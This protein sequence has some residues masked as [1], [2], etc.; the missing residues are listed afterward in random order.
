MESNKLDIG[1]TTS[2]FTPLLQENDFAP[3]W[4][5]DAADTTG[6]FQNGSSAVADPV[7]LPYMPLQVAP[8]P[9]KDMHGAFQ[10]NTHYISES[11]G[12]AMVDLNQL[13]NF[14]KPIIDPNSFNVGNT[15]PCLYGQDLQY[16]ER[17]VKGT[18]RIRD[19][20]NDS[21]DF[22]SFRD[23][24][25]NKRIPLIRSTIG[26][27]YEPP[28]GESGVRN[29]SGPQIHNFIG[30]GGSSTYQTPNSD[31]PQIKNFLVSG[32]SKTNNTQNSGVASI[33]KN[34]ELCAA[35]FGFPNI[36]DGSFLSLGIGSNSD[37]KSKSDHSNREITGGG[38]YGAVNP[39]LNT[40]CAQ[41]EPGRSFNP[42]YNF[43]GGR[44]SFQNNVGG[45]SSLGNH[46]GGWTSSYNNFGVRGGINT[47]PNSSQLAQFHNVQKPEA[48]T[49]HGFPASSTKDLGMDRNARYPNLDAY[50]GFIGPRRSGSTQLL[51]SGQ[52]AASG[53]EPGSVKLCWTARPT[54]DRLQKHLAETV[55]K[56]SP[57]SSMVSSFIGFKGSSTRQEHSGQLYTAS[58]HNAAQSVDGNAQPPRRKHVQLAGE[59]NPLIPELAYKTLMELATGTLAS[60][61]MQNAKGEFANTS[62][63]EGTLVQSLTYNKGQQFSINDIAA[64]SGAV[65]GMF[66]KRLGVQVSKDSAPQAAGSDLFPQRLGVHFNEYRAAPAAGDGLFH[67]STGIKG[68]SR[69][70]LQ[71]HLRKDLI[72]PPF[73]AGQAFSTANGSGLSQA[74]NV[75]GV[76]L[77]SLKRRAMQPPPAAPRV[78][79][80]KITL[81]PPVHPYILSSQ[82]APAPPHIKWK[83]FT[84]I[85]ALTLPYSCHMTYI[86][87][88]LG[89]W[90]PT[91]YP[92]LSISLDGLPQPIGQKCMLCKRDLSF[93]PEG[94][95]HQPT[96]PPSVA[97]LPC[98]HTFHDNCLQTITPED[99]SKDPPCIP[100][101]IGEI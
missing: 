10:P 76:P 100:C 77:P 49:Q 47:C 91:L 78:Q 24:G 33:V 90:L 53:L 70:G 16:P 97:V 51:D 38:L 8:F 62:V 50:K 82:A 58:K 84:S 86:P 19:V 68:C 6:M 61:N 96:V 36:V 73:P 18:S 42:G 31:G 69:E 9:W 75:V 45:F 22:N 2:F 56:L 48:N 17:N 41:Q 20:M 23:P 1:E 65:G 11:C 14:Q 57:E 81:P 95:V 99:Q 32:G 44:P 7:S 60:Y 87:N 43:V 54:S 29:I 15:I 98:G 39:Q 74:S 83:A 67:K 52:T 94:P 37:V 28:S 40:S 92:D 46:V 27:G 72:R 25:I 35:Q 55:N 3:Y 64:P 93:T 12:N 80:R 101:A 21:V 59:P 5:N 89:I 79:R 63:P 4:R 88:K 26:G 30:S 66:P 71:A 34:D 13:H 85:L